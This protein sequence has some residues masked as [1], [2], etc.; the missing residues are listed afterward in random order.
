VREG[1]RSR[2][3]KASR[4]FSGPGRGHD[5]SGRITGALPAMLNSVAEFFERT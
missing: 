3:L 1:Q 2:M 4:M 5:R